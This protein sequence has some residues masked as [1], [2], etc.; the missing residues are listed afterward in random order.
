MRVEAPWTDDQIRSLNAYQVEARVHPFTSPN[1]LDLIATR[2]GWREDLSGPVV[3]TW[4][5]DF[6]A[7]WRWK[8]T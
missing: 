1:G 2:E 7:D 4:A 6:M 5:H 8:A 3:Q